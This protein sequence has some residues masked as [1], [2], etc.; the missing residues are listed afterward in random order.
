MSTT[1][2]LTHKDILIGLLAL[3][4]IFALGQDY[5]LPSSYNSQRTTTEALFGTG[6]TPTQQQYDYDL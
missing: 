1:S 4:L 6:Y 3:L 2:R 5:L